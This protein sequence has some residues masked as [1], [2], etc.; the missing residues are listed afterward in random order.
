MA[1]RIYTVSEFMPSSSRS[2][3]IVIMI[4]GTRAGN[5]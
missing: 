4:H 5:C 1:H 3:V 2:F